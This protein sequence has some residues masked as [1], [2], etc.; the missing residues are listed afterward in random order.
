MQESQIEKPPYDCDR[1]S[2]LRSNILQIRS[3]EPEWHNGPVNS[4]G[5]LNAKLLI[6]GLAPGL[7]GANRTGRVFTGDQ[8][9][10]LLYTTLLKFGLASGTYD[11][12]GQDSLVVKNCRI[13]NAVRCLPPENKPNRSELENCS[14]FL[15]NELK[16]MPNLKVVLALGVIAH[17]AILSTLAKPKSLFKFKHN[18]FHQLENMI[19][20]NS[21]HCSR[22]NMNTGRLTEVM[23]HD[24]FRNILTYI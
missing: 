23:F 3:K 7:K 18:T 11:S 10:Y 12:S 17:Q 5:N 14:S 16:N 13:T 1:C 4:F 24:V 22:Y 2:R 6:V 21:Y 15:F 20:G 19:I 8:S 9:G